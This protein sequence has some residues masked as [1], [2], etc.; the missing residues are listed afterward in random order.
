MSGSP[1]WL[2]QLCLTLD[3]DSSHDL[4]VPE[5]KLHLGLC[6]D[7]MQPA[8]DPVSLS[9]SAPSLFMCMLSPSQY[10]YI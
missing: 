6:R 3:F 9:L 4:M 5:F 1:G 8:S 10:I 2:S 7:R